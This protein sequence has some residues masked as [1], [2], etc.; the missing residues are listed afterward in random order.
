MRVA[1]AALLLAACAKDAYDLAP[2]ACP[3]DRVCANDPNGGGG[4]GN[5]SGIACIDGKCQHFTACNPVRAGLQTTCTATNSKCTLVLQGTSEIVGACVPQHG[6]G[7]GVNSPCTMSVPPVSSGGVR[8]PTG[9]PDACSP[10]FICATPLFDP[11]LTPLCH[12][13]CGAD[14]D[15]T[16]S[17]ERCFQVQGP[18]FGALVGIC[19]PSCNLA[20]AN[21]CPSGQACVLI[22]GS[23]DISGFCATP[24]TLKLGDLCSLAPGSGGNYP[25]PQLCQAGLQCLNDTSGVFR[26][27]ATCTPS[28]TAC[29]AGTTCSVGSSCGAGVCACR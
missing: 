14:A 17:G 24:G 3:E 7:L 25:T 20:D 15:C 23:Q 9:A 29:P 28:N 16:I 5:N 2:Y 1:L 12:S 22:G 10:G 19:F 6:A 11:A 26:C 21:A 8:Y 27:T 4:A 13:F 18:S